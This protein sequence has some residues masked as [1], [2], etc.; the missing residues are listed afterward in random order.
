VE[1]YVN[2]PENYTEPEIEPYVQGV[3]AFNNNVNRRNIFEAG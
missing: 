2:A 1:K 3:F